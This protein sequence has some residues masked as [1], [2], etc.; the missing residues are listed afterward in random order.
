MGK[1]NQKNKNS[2]DHGGER[3]SFFQLLRS[4]NVPVSIICDL[5]GYS[6]PTIY[7]YTDNTSF[8]AANYEIL[9]MLNKAMLTKT[10]LDAFENVDPALARNHALNINNYVNSLKGLEE[11]RE[12]V[13]S[14]DEQISLQKAM[15]EEKGLSKKAL[16]ILQARFNRILEGS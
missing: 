15:T 1:K 13:T 3:K 8:P 12:T 16:D 14:R 5:S 2:V 9:V 7:R 11:W 6:D 10:Y 4:L